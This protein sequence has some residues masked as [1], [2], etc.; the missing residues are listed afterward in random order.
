MGK[1]KYWPPLAILPEYPNFALCISIKKDWTTI[2][3]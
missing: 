1:I 3:L 2:R